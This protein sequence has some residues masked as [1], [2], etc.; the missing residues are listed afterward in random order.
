MTPLYTAWDRP[1]AR[2]VCRGDLVIVGASTRA[3]AFSA[4]RAGLCPRCADLFADRDLRAACPVIRIA[5]ARYPEGFADVLTSDWPGPWMFTGALENHPGLVDRGAELRPLLGTCG[6]PLRFTRNPLWLAR[7]LAANGWRGP[8][9]R[10]RPPAATDPARWLRKP[11]RGCGGTGIGFCNGPRAARPAGRWFF[12]EFLEGLPCSAIFLAHRHAD[13]LGATRQLIGQPWLHARPFQYCGNLAPLALTRP[14]R[15]ALQGLADWL[16]SRGLHGLFG[17]DF[18]LHA[19]WPWVLEINPRYTAAVEVIEHATGLDALGLAWRA[20]HDP[21][22]VVPL[23]SRSAAAPV[24]GKAIYYARSRLVFPEEG[25][26]LEALHGFQPGRDVPPF[27]DIPH[28]GEIIDQGKPVLT[29]FAKAATV[30]G[31]M[32]RLQLVA[33]E[34]DRRLLGR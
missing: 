24:V 27:A 22:P 14:Q 31:C 10:R 29:I 11:L 26:W 16:C 7:A 3:A 20:V 25:P 33:A 5:S 30:E 4:L 32:E 15:A 8:R 28:P 1:D 34:L 17:I 21:G 9:T 6:P 23:A 19:G 2:A 18:L 12:Q 13:L